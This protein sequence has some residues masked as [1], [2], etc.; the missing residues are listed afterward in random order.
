MLSWLETCRRLYNRCLRD[1]KD[2][3]NSRKC[4][5]DRCSLDREYIMPTETP[6]PGYIE[7]KRQLTQWKKTNPYLKEVHSQVTQD[8]VKRLHNSWESFRQRG[9]G[10][11]RYKKYGR[12]LTKFGGTETDTANFALSIVFVSSIQK[13][14]NQRESD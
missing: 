7:Q 11:P 10:F 4:T 5:I 13:Q 9:R 8:V 3:M 2:W 1:L 6:F 14:S 12:S